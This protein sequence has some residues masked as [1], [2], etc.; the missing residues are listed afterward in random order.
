MKRIWCIATLL[1]V[2]LTL[3]PVLNRGIQADGPIPV[4]EPHRGPSAVSELDAVDGNVSVNSVWTADGD[5]N[6]K[7]TFSPVS[8]KKLV[9]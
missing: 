5:G 1:A 3:I 8:A 7:S 2:C 4:G 9:A 6:R